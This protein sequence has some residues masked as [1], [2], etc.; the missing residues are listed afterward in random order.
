MIAVKPY[1]ERDFSVLKREETICPMD[2]MNYNKDF[3]N[4]SK[5]SKHRVASNECYSKSFTPMTEPSTLDINPTI[6]RSS[7]FCGHGVQ[8]RDYVQP[9]EPT[10]LYR[11]CPGITF[12]PKR[13]PI[14]NILS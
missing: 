13:V 10:I 11:R 6:F 3:V 12:K 4:F 8:I 14:S 5:K 2:Y 9:L 1:V 7:C